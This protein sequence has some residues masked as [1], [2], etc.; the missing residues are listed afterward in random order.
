MKNPAVIIGAI[1]GFICICCLCCFFMFTFSSSLLIGVL[2]SDFKTID[3]EVFQQVCDADE[4]DLRT[5][6]DKY[7]SQ[8]Y[9]EDTTFLEFKK[10]YNDNMNFF[11]SCDTLVEDFSW[12][13]FFNDFSINSNNT[14]SS[15][16][17]IELEFSYKGERITLE[18][19]KEN[20]RY[21]IN[22]LDIR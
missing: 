18:V 13:D 15:N 10:F 12:R 6:Y 5:V 17:T 11:G 1:V 4:N 22:Y 20:D 16:H 8:N 14:G 3:E 7:F 2:V 9:K 19:I 21:V